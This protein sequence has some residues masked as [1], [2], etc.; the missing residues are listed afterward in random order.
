MDFRPL[1]RAIGQ[2]DRD[3]GTYRGRIASGA[4]QPDRPG[5]VAGVAGVHDLHLWTLGGNHTV[6]TA[7]L[8]CDHTE[9]PN[10][11]LRA[12]TRLLDTRFGITHTTLQIEPPDYNIVETV[13]PERER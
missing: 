7:H 8:V 13:E 1:G 9:S 2:E 6:L 11:L 3:L 12:A 4:F 10:R 5:T